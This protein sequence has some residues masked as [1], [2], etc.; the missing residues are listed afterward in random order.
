MPI[1]NIKVLSVNDAF[2]GRRF[3]T[4]ECEAYEYELFYR[5]PKLTIPEGDLQIWIVFGV[6]NKNFDYDNGIKI[7]QD[8]LQK[9]YSFNDKRIMRGIIDKHIVKKDNEFI[10]FQLI[11]IKDNFIL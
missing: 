5:L 1:I 9:K 7:F 8:C 10:A 2:Q 6:S 4:K 11:S 3:K